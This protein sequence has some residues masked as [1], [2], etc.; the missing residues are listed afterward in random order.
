MLLYIISYIVVSFV[1]ASACFK[2]DSRLKTMDIESP[3]Q[4][5]VILLL[6]W[7]L[8]FTLTI[9]SNVFIFIHTVCKRYVNFLIK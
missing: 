8:I 6:L 2:F 5:F 9:I 4:A 1:I 7:P 3:V